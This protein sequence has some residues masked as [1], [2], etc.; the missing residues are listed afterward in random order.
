MAVP[1][2]DLKLWI[3][4]T[5]WIARSLCTK[6]KYQYIGLIGAVEWV[7]STLPNA[8]IAQM[9]ER[10]HEQASKEAMLSTTSPIALCQDQWRILKSVVI[11]KYLA[12]RSASHARRR[13]AAGGEGEKQTNSGVSG[14]SAAASNKDPSATPTTH[15][16]DS[17]DD[18]GEFFGK[19]Y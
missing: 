7:Y 3:L 19:L 4:V 18:E 1:A 6:T 13:A 5:D 10:I 12:A 14:S 16:R 11:D 17:S 15:P 2:V 8:E 9:V